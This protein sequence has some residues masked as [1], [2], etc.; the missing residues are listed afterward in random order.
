[1]VYVTGVMVYV[2][3]VMVYVTG[4]TVYVTG[5]M[6]YVTGVMVYVTRVMVYVT[7]VTV[8]VTGVMVY[9]TGVM[10]YVTGV[11]VYVTGVMV[12][13]TGVMVYVT[14]VMVC[15]W[16][17]GIV[18]HHW[19]Y[20][21]LIFICPCIVIYSYS[22]TNKMHLLSQIIYSC[23]TFYMFR[24]VFPSIIRSSKLRIQQ[25]YMSSSCCYRG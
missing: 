6:V 23:K 20:V 5:V 2:T 14:V 12:Y 1:M 18:T 15:H 7:G 10:V 17:Y 25:R 24:T 4:V 22:T 8:Y 11:T 19:C 16:D 3:G 13:V 9:V 21:H